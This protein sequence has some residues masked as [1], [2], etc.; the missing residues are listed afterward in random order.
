MLSI[1]LQLKEARNAENLLSLWLQRFG[2]VGYQLSCHIMKFLLIYMQT[3][4]DRHRARIYERKRE[5]EGTGLLLKKYDLFCLV[6][7]F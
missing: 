6:E 2:W 7:L 1:V 3:E 5:G 4:I